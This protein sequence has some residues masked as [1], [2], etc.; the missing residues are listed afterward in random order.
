[1]LTKSPFVVGDG[2]QWRETDFYWHGAVRMETVPLFISNFGPA[3]WNLPLE[4]SSV[5]ST[6]FWTHGVE[7]MI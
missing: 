6:I 3:D 2:E 4:L 1:M 5:S 7:N